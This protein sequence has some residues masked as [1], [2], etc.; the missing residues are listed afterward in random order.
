MKKKLLAYLSLFVLFVLF[1]PCANAKEIEKEKVICNYEYEGMTLSYKVYD[2][3]VVLPFKDGENNWYHG[4]EFKN[5]YISSSKENSITYVCPTITIEKSDSFTTIFNNPVNEDNCNGICTTISAT[6]MQSSK[7]ITVKK[8]VDTTAIGSVGIYNNASYFLPYF[9]LLDDGTKQWSVNGKQFFATDETI[10]IK[11]LNTKVKLDKKLEKEIYKENKLNNDVK[12]YRNVKEKSN[13]Y[14]YLLSTEKEKGYSLT[15]GQENASASYNG[16]L[17]ANDNCVGILGNPNDSK[18]VAWLVQKILD[19]M[20][21]IAPF[22]VVIMSGIDFAKVVILSDDENM[23]KAQS[24]L[25]TRLLLAGSLFFLVEIVRAL[26][27]LF[28]LTT[29]PLCGIN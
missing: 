21:V 16:A 3:K 27:A 20:R 11:D 2:D 28:G 6:T 23:K 10:L 24:K 9:R 12:I 17:G 18:S 22:I 4:A 7:N 8:A 13:A 1:M 14:T 5:T 19:Y 15:D 26:L 29:N 25:I